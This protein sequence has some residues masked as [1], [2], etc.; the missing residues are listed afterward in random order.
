MAQQFEVE[1]VEGDGAVWL[2]ITGDLDDATTPE[3]VAIAAAAGPAERLVLDLTP[4]TFLDSGGIRG[5]VAVDQARS[6]SGTVVVLSPPD[7][8]C[9][10]VLDIVGLADTIAVVDHPEQV[11][12]AMAPAVSEGAPDAPPAA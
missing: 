2:R 8:P 4:C 5:L 11:P 1:V 3:L 7:G 6:S 12:L 9:R 10:L